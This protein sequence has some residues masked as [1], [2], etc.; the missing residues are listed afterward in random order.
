PVRVR[1]LLSCPQEFPPVRMPFMNFR[2]VFVTLVFLLSAVGAGAGWFWYSNRPDKLYES[3]R[4][5]YHQGETLRGA[6]DAAK[7]KAATPARQL[8]KGPGGLRPRPDPDRP[9]PEKGRRQGPAS[10]GRLHVALQDPATAGGA[11]R[12]G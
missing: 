4:E 1:L 10:L 6:G 12:Q 3:A 9:F 5:S 2:I 11:R 7:A 8:G